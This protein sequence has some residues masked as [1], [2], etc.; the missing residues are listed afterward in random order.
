MAE[1]LPDLLT[2]EE[3]ARVLRIGRTAAYGLTR[4]WRETGGREG[5]PVVNLGRLLRVPR[6]ALEAATGAELTGPPRDAPRASAAEPVVG[7][8][9]TDSKSKHPSYERRASTRRS[10]RSSAPSDVQATL[11]F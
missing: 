3:A 5:L 8:S 10:R 9:D 1:Q 2:V 4:V 11:P 7:G 6:S